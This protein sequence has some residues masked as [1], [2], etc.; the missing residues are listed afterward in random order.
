MSVWCKRLPRV[1]VNGHQTRRLVQSSRDRALRA[2]RW[3]H[4]FSRGRKD[5]RPF[6]AARDLTSPDLGK[7]PWA[8]FAEQASEARWLLILAQSTPECPLVDFDLARRVEA[9]SQERGNF[10][11]RVR[12]PRSDS[13]YL[14]L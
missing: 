9:K 5:C 12:Y 14:C 4:G 8:Q 1:A 3:P 6:L 7:C 11:I 2:L 13:R 10:G